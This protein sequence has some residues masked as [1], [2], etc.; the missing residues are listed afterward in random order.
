MVLATTG[1]KLGIYNDMAS[2]FH[3]E[4]VVYTEDGVRPPVD[5][6]LMAVEMGRNHVMILKNHGVIF[7]GDSL[8]NTTVEA[9]YLREVRSDRH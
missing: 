8:E 9:F 1:R 3:E 7:L 5:G 6:D 2:L 4:Q